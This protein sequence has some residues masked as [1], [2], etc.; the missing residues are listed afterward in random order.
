MVAACR[1]LLPRTRTR[2]LT[3]LLDQIARHPPQWED[4]Q[5]NYY[6]WYYGTYALFQAG[7]QRWRRWNL[8]MQDALLPHQRDAGCAR[9]SWDAI[10]E[11]CLVGGRVYATALNALTLEI[12]YRYRRG[13]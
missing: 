11:W 6:Y 13:A 12:Y 3:P 4:T 10:G 7:G 5:R 9:G 1:Q 8:A 2:S